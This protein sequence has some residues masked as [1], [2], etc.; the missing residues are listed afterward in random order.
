ME[1]PLS[2]IRQFIKTTEEPISKIEQ[3]IKK[4]ENAISEIG[5]VWFVAKLEALNR[6]KF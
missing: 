5:F 3:P 6:I 2:E 4:M 1:N